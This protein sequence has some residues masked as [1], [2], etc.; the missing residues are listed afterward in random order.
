MVPFAIGKT[1]FDMKDGSPVPF[2]GTTSIPPSFSRAGTRESFVEA[3]TDVSI[4]FRNVL[5]DEGTATCP[6]DFG[7]TWLALE[8]SA[9][10]L[11]SWIRLELLSSCMTCVIGATNRFPAVRPK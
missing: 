8:L 11:G 7:G 3:P 9:L 6:G 4:S 5:I 1:G 2:G 10:G